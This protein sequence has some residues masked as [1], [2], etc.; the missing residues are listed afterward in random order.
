MMK[1]I[2]RIH[3]AKVSYDI[4]IGAKK[5]LEKYIGNLEAYAD[6]QEL[7]QDIE[8]RITELLEAR[9]VKQNDVI[10][11]DDVAAVRGQLGEP[12]EF[13]GEGDVAIGPDADLSGEPNR[14][15]YRNIDSAVLGGVLSGIGTFFKIDPVW[16]RLLFI[17]L[18]IV[19]AGTAALVYAVLWI[20]VPPART[21]AEK[22]Q[23]AGRP[24]TLSSIREL[25]EQD[26]MSRPYVERREYAL[27]RALSLG[28]GIFCIAGAIIALIATIGGGLAVGVRSGMLHDIDGPTIVI[29]IGLCLLSGL[30]LV[31]LFI[32]GAYA[33]FTRKLAKKQIVAA[34]I[35]TAL[36]LGSLG[37]GVGLVAYSQWQ[38]QNSIQ[39]AVRT[40]EGALPD[41]F[42]QQIKQLHV[43]ISDMPD[44]RVEYIVDTAKTPRYELIALPGIKPTVSLDGQ[45]ATVSLASTSDSPKQYSLQ[46]GSPTLK[47]YGPSLE[48][49]EADNGSV[50]Y[51]GKDQDRFEAIAHSGVSIETVGTYNT[52]STVSEINSSI[53]LDQSSVRE[54]I[55]KTAPGGYVTAG[56]VRTLTVIQP[57][58]CPGDNNPFNGRTYVSAQAVT[59]G[60]V[61]YNGVSLPA[62]TH[63]TSCAALKIGNENSN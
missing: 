8:I 13:M 43:A 55:A 17:V 50:F 30:L 44:V 26:A 22:L 48:K 1:E 11:S 31:A 24:V 36:G 10:T 57:D 19:S 45:V 32:M 6:D 37:V 51:A 39:Q 14:K 25:N 9:G 15:L 61:T 58:V 18:L 54:L 46:F 28:A 47:I 60:T 20:V 41:N 4:E 62:K 63:T 27:K 16:V 3:I 40:S 56:T 53:G 59:S 7:L 29:A 23:L 38:L 42:T 21:A 34:V 5:E 52:V 12:K 35:V 49:L 2:T 33:A